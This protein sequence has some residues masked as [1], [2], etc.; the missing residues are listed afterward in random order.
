ML[1]GCFASGT[2]YG[3]LES[4]ARA[5]WQKDNKMRLLEDVA[6]IDPDGGKWTVPKGY[7]TDGASIPKAFWS[8]IGGPL[9][10]PYR[11]AALIHDWYCDYK[12]K[13]WKDV[14]RVF[15]YA[16]R[17]KG[18]ADLKAKTMYAAVRAGAPKWGKDAS[19]C[20]GCHKNKPYQRDRHGNLAV[21]PKLTGKDANRISAWIDSRN[22]TLE[23]IDKFIESNYPNSNFGHQRQ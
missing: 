12:T 16:C 4:T 11:E 6:Y 7:E 19:T 5:E 23:E 9:E 1:S 2:N 18:V 20:D 10:G 22:P 17:A 21:T 8:V 15:Y 3:H 14:H 13:P